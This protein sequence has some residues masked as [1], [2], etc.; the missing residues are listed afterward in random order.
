MRAGRNVEAE[1]EF[2]NATRLDPNLP[3]AH[4]DLGLVLGREGKIAEAIPAIRRALAL[5]A[6][7]ESAHLFLGIFEYNVGETANAIA[8]LQQE[9]DRS[10]KNIEALSWM[11]IVQLAAGHPELAVAPLDRAVE[12]SP[13]NLDLLEYRGRAHS[14]VAQA[15]YAKMG[16]IDPDAWQVHKVRAE[17][18]VGDGKDRDAITEYL[19]A[20]AKANKNPDLYEGLGDAYRRL[21]ELEQ[22]QKAYAREVDLAPQNPIA[23]YNLGS[24]D[25]DRG[26]Y[27]AG[28]SLLKSMIDRYPDS[29]HAEYYLGRG[30][31]ETNHDAD[32]AVM[33]ERSAHADGSGEI[34]KRSYYQLIR[35]YRKLQ[36]PQDERR[37][38]AAY[39]QLRQD[40]E[41]KKADKLADWR[42]LNTASPAPAATQP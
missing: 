8:D 21:N 27:A 34:A 37:V 39:N 3:E 33:L 28:V 7:L 9:I 1:R 15:S 26:D 10:P 42:K 35:I 25:I 29:S 4:L 2:R 30:L 5:N 38:L 13:S 12:Q 18:F 31:A 6:E 23:L 14:L 19:A 16:Q 22:A 36:R 41:K 40:E 24:T 11:G 17:L 32:A 20:L